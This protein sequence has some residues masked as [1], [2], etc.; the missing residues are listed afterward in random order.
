MPVGPQ[1][2]IQNPFDRRSVF[3]KFDYD[4]TPSITA[5][6]QALYVDSTV[7]TSSGGSLTQFG[8]LTTIPI[9][10]PF[11]PADLRTVLAS[12]PNPNASFTWNGRYVGLPAKAWDE[13]Y[14]TNQFLG[15]LR[16]KLPMDGW[17]WDAF[18]SYDKTDH[19][20]SNYNAVLKSRVQALLNAPDGGNSICSGG[21]NPFGIANATRI[22]E[23]CRSYMT[24]TAQS[25]EKLTQSMW[26]AVLQGPVFS[27]PAGEVNVAFLADWRRNTY[28]YRP[29][30]A[31]AAQ[32][33]EAVIAAAP[34]RGR[35]SVH[36]YAAQIDV[37]LLKDAPFAESLNVGGAYRYS[38]YNTSGGVSSYEGEVKWRPVGDLLLRASYQRA[39]RAPNIGELFSAA[40]GVQIAFGTPPGSI[41]DPCDVRSNGRTG[42]GGAQVRTLCLA[43][44]VPAAVIDTYTFPTTATG[45]LQQGNPDLTPER[46]NTYNLGAVWTS[47]LE[48]PGLSNLSVSV[49]YW[50][51]DISDVISVVPGLT[52]LS[53]CYNLDGSNPTYSASNE[54]CQLLSRDSNGQLQIIRTPYLNLGGLKTDGV[55]IQVNWKLTLEDVGLGSLGDEVFINSGISR[56][57]AY[58]IQTLPGTR[59]Q[60]FVGTN[61]IGAPRPKWKALTTLGYRNGPGMLSLR[62]RYMDGMKDVTS[63]TTPLTPGIGVEPYSYFD[64]VGSF[65][66]REDWELR[67]GVTNVFDKGLPIV[68]SSQTSTDTATFDAVGRSFYV[69]LRASF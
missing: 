39:V 53:K 6:G 19:H 1:T 47:S 16:G 57:L 50:N 69:G 64:V 41:G 3:A 5:Y 13:A 34:S 42:A 33:I 52:A 48:A 25:T 4:L 21:F 32:D 45:G 65:E 62:W 14:T 20:Q 15:G 59:F 29:D 44:G 7:F 68:S 67:A 37:P 12:R 66:I 51:I 2:F 56:T 30:A 36:E 49:D 60:E 9:T 63:V 23:A 11:I 8:T 46:A 10:N 24:I 61:T 54:F 58:K 18:A 31:L 35:I 27:L 26:Q 55:D 38:D 22:S 43:Q 28:D 40:T 17:T